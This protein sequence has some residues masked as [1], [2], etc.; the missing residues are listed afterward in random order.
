[1]TPLS[2]TQR[3]LPSYLASC[4]DTPFELPIRSEH[5]RSRNPVPHDA[6]GV[7]LLEEFLATEVAEDS[8]L[9]DRL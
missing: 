3:P 4:R 6:G 7:E 9:D 5:D 1:P 8:L 2:R